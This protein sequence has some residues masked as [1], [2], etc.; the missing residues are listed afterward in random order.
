MIRRTGNKVNKGSNPEPQE[1]S[2]QA[3]EESPDGR[4]EI[5]V[6]VDRMLAKM[7]LIP[8]K[9]GG[10]HL[11]EKE[12]FEKIQ[13]A[14]VVKGIKEETVKR[15]A[16]NQL[17]N[18]PFKF[19]YGMLPRDGVDEELKCYFNTNVSYVPKELEDGTVDYRNMGMGS[20]SVKEGDLVAEIT[21][22]VAG[23]DGYDVYGNAILGKPGKPIPPTNGTNVIL[24]ED[25]TKLYAAIDGNVSLKDG[26]VHIRKELTIESVDQSV[27]NVFFPGDVIIKHDVRNGFTVRAG[28]SVTIGGVVE[29]ATVI[30]GTDMIIKVGV[31]G[32]DS[33]IVSGGALTMGYI[34][35]A[36]ATAANDVFLDVALNA[37]ISCQ[38]SV[39]FKGK[40]SCLIGG[41]VN[42]GT[43][44]EARIIGNSTYV[45]TNVNI[46]KPGSRPLERDE[47]SGQI[48]DIKEKLNIIDNV[49]NETNKS[50][51]S[52]GEKREALQKLSTKRKNAM[53]ELRLLNIE[54]NQYPLLEVDD[55]DGWITVKENIYP[56]VRININGVEA[57]N[58]VQRPVCKITK[59]K[60]KLN[61]G[62]V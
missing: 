44:I 19:A 22:A 28:G 48:K 8:P 13:E 53:E 46:T 24:S 54:L 11:T 32:E 57:R 34:E 31:H 43:S 21:P 47:I 6:Q 14:G 10:K 18:M 15:I 12:I 35:A 60:G 56:N 42:A 16:G 26:K 38:G 41:T 17:Y 20:D 7:T 58:D 39:T 23:E 37:T 3:V 52:V 40:K 50:N 25:G 49:I 4:V 45:V 36:K 51:K 33:N 55:N 30:S 29:S 61:Y 59:K 27:G 1:K 62:T 9:E 5:E 2:D